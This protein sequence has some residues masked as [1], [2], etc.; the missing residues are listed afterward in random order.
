V[1]CP[2]ADCW[3]K[4]RERLI[5][6]TGQTYTVEELTWDPKAPAEWWGLDVRVFRY[7]LEPQ[8]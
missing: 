8:G 1:S 6:S 2:W 5:P 4:R 3:C 7:R